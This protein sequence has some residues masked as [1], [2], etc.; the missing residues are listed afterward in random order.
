MKTRTAGRWGA[1]AAI[2][3]GLVLALQVSPAS[4]SPASAC[5]CGVI[6]PGSDDR[7]KVSGTE[8][9]VRWDGNREVIDLAIDIDSDAASAGLVFPTPRPATVTAG[10]PDLFDAVREQAEPDVTIVDDW[11]GFGVEGQSPDP[12]EPVVLNTVRIGKL[13]ATT[14]E[15]SDSSGLNAWLKRND[16]SIS[17]AARDALRSYVDKGWSFVAVKL[18]DIPKKG[19][20][21]ATPM[22][23][24]LEPVSFS[25]SSSELVYPMRVSGVSQSPQDLRLYVFDDHR[26]QLSQYDAPSKPVN[27]AQTTV[28]AGSTADTQLSSLGD[29]LTVF[30]LY[31]DDP[32][33]QSRSDL[34]VTD[35]LADEQYIPQLVLANPITI[36]DIPVG[37]IVVGW[38]GFGVIL[39]LAYITSRLRLR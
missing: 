18:T 32:K 25:F 7:A 36:L 37:L 16:Y 5:V 15:A 1:V 8:A 24:A 35:A 26:V 39:A 19:E 27:A 12:E 3:V 30:D 13:S 2:S 23:G 38:G 4:V 20:S 22:R 6:T 28:W 14:L 21:E 31:L 10:D 34:V 17:N 33:S 11:W 29:F 9:I